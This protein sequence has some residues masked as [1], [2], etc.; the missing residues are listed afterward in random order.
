M[1]RPHLACNFWKG[2]Q[3]QSVPT[4]MP[5]H[6]SFETAAT[7]LN[8]VLGC[9][10][11]HERGA[12]WRVMLITLVS[13]GLWASGELTARGQEAVLKAVEAKPFSPRALREALAAPLSE[14]ELA[15]WHRRCL[16]AFG[17]Q[18]LAKNRAGAR[19]EGT[20][21]AW[22]VL[23]P[24]PASVVRAD[25]KL[26][27]EMVA[28]G[29]D[30]LQV[31]ALELPNFSE[32][33]FRIEVDGRTQQGGQVRVEHYELPPESLPAAEVPTGRLE[34]FQWN[35][36]KVFPGTERQVTVYLP[37]G[38][39]PQQTT[40]LMVWQDGSRHADPAG[41]LRVPVVFD[42]LIHRGEMPPTVG[43]FVDPGRRPGQ[44]PGEKPSNRSVEYDSLGAAYS[45]F[46]LTEILPEVKKRFATRW[47]EQPTAWAIAGGSSGGICAF[48]A[49]WER[50]DRFQKVLSWV[51]SFTDIRGGHA[52]P[53]M[54]RQAEPK[55]LR[56]YLLGGENDLDNPFGHWPLANRLMAKALAYHGYD[57]HLEWT[58]CFHGTR[59]MAPKLPDALRWLW[60]DWKTTLK[61]AGAP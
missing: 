17:H 52:Y 30:G 31:L 7:C 26:L 8:R 22:A 28:L 39:Q 49:A 36:S 13:S 48:T 32:L 47:I 57:Y 14:A 5:T 19:I 10:S 9:G 50:P 35:D 46:L 3:V 15:S 61:L 27:G 6:F 40:C 12:L 41:Q 44:K 55:P 24:A 20:T 18:A 2:T 53:S 42:H 34:T 60:R 38:F 1:R 29:Q 23:A 37:A 33:R 51:G 25:G 11:K 21:V 58:D 43:V 54:I 4:G 45:D 56:V 59:G 16:R